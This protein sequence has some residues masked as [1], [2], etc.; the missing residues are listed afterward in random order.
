[1][2]LLHLFVMS[3]QTKLAC[4]FLFQIPELHMAESADI[5][6][7]D[8]EPHIVALL[9]EL[10]MDAGYCV[11]TASNGRIA[12][13]AIEQQLPA[14]ILLDYMM[15]VLSGQE[16]VRVLRAQGYDQWPIIIKSAVSTAEPFRR[17]GVTDFLPKPFVLV[18]VL[19]YV[20]HAIGAGSPVGSVTDDESQTRV[21]GG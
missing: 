17:T 6:V 8:D 18:E 15:P 3:P 1:L 4:S 5:L 9:A 2:R 14:L 20:E 10:L 11:R 7:V 16:V 12:L 21:V 13:A 19:A